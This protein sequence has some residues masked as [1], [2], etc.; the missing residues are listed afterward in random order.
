MHTRD[1]IDTFGNERSKMSARLSALRY[2]GEAVAGLRQPG[3]G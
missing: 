1:E 3:I 2:V